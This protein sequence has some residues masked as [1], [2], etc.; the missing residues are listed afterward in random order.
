LTGKL[1]LPGQWVVAVASQIKQV[2]WDS[3]NVVVLSYVLLLAHGYD[4][5]HSKYET[6]SVAF[7]KIVTVG[8]CLVL[9]LVCLFA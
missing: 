5:I 1:T 9:E 6:T 7:F 2:G 8:H 4:G 3:N